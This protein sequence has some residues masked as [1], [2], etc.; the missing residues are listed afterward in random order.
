MKIQMI[1]LTLLVSFLEIVT[2]SP[3]QAEEQSSFAVLSG[4]DKGQAALEFEHFPS[5]LHTFLWRNWSVVSAERLAAVLETTVENVNRIAVTMGLPLQQNILPIWESSQGYITVLRRNWHLLPYSQLLVLLNQTPEQLADSLQEDDFLFIKLG[6]VKPQC[7]PLRFAEPTEEQNKKAAKIVTWI[8]EELGNHWTDSEEARFEFLKTFFPNEKKTPDVSAT[9][10]LNGNDTSPFEIR[11]LF[12]YFATFGDPLLDPEIKSYPDELLRQLSQ[13]GVNGIWLHT[14]LRTLAP[15]DLF[16]EFGKDHEIRLRSLQTLVDR[17]NRYGIKVYLYMNEPRTMPKEFFKGDRAKL[18]GVPYG[19]NTSLC[20]STP[21]VRRWISDSLTYVFKNV[22]GLG[23]IFTITASENHTNCTSH[24]RKDQCPRCKDRSVAEI[25]AEVNRVMADAIHRVAPNAQVLVWDW[26]WRD[27][28]APE[29]IAQLPDSVWLMSVSEWSLPI[30]RGGV[31]SNV[32]EYSISSIGPGPRA[33]KHWALARNR[34]LK[35]AAKVQFNVTWEFASVPYLPVADL[36]AEHAS[37]L[38]GSGVNGLMLGW[39]LGGY[40]SPNLEI[41]KAFQSSSSAEIQDKNELL[42][43][44]NEVLDRIAQ[45]YYGNGAAAAREAWT[46]FSNGF[47]EFPYHIGLCYNGPQHWGAANLIFPKRTGYRATMVGIPYDDVQ[48]W[49]GIYPPDVAAGQF[50]KVAG[51]FERGLKPLRQAVEQSPAQRKF[52]TESEFRFA[53]AA[54]F[55][56]ASSANMIEFNTLRNRWLDTA[57][58]TEKENLRIKIQKVLIDEL[59]IAKSMYDIAKSDSRIGY[60][61]SNHYFYIPI[62]VA[63]KIISIKYFLE[64]F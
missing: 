7:Q 64:Y 49:C 60:E 12:S 43:R 53:Q 2:I 20:T 24:Y 32:G 34:G 31:K 22:T 41:A 33:L 1:L 61:S 15:S 47:R 17:A 62:D 27:D 57:D 35:T 38:S 14:V 26:G 45:E 58:A 10:N 8:R 55:H 44:Q 28:V 52:Q 46:L 18:A 50:R 36:I 54:Q 37:N 40:P 56:F 39:S 25:I 59:G 51:F 5:R 63:E 4:F 23:G 21:E 6:S 48:N 42:K 13:H 9:T 19:A 29:I 3:S 11:F 16:P 30:E